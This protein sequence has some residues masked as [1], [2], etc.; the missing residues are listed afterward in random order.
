MKQKHEI[1]SQQRVGLRS[2]CR[3]SRPS[4]LIRPFP[5]TFLVPWKCPRLMENVSSRKSKSQKSPRTR[6]RKLFS[7][8]LVLTRRKSFSFS[9][10]TSRREEE[11][12]GTRR[13]PGTKT[14]DQHGHL[15]RS[16]VQGEPH[17]GRSAV[18][19]LAESPARTLLTFPLTDDGHSVC[20]LPGLESSTHRRRQEHAST[21]TYAQT[22]AETRLEHDIVRLRDSLYWF[23]RRHHS[24]ARRETRRPTSWSRLNARAS[25]PMYSVDDCV[26]LMHK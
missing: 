15:L 13:I 20:A 6:K 26:L 9:L 17:A 24:H 1:S 21:Q 25:V 7:R 16:F 2:P 5:L 11:R 10:S 12:G 4:T 22:S 18:T 19:T 8:F 14:G 3:C 23:R